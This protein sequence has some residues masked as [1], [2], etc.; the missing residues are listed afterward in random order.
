MSRS[1]HSLKIYN[2]KTHKTYTIAAY[3]QKEECNADN[4][5]LP[6][7]IANQSLFMPI[8]PY[9]GD[10]AAGGSTGVYT[11][12]NNK[13]YQ[14]VQNGEFYLKIQQTPNQTIT[15]HVG[16]QSWTDENEHWFPYGTQ[17]TATIVGHDGYNPGALNV[18]SGTLTDNNVTVTATGATFA[19]VSCTMKVSKHKTTY[20]CTEFTPSTIK[21]VQ[22]NRLT[23]AKH[24]H[25]LDVLV[26]N[27]AGRHAIMLVGGI[28]LDM[29]FPT[30]GHWKAPYRQDLVD[31]LNSH[32][33]QTV[34]I[35]ILVY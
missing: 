31:Y 33:E 26:T 3:T 29:T 12:K 28:S 16:G 1:P 19:Y 30:D 25:S 5:W 18:S 7:L 24:V 23:T 21:G 20:I 8:T 22:F 11:I 34:P 10:A 15:L 9:L 2:N 13:T 17:W 35:Q 4:N 27:G 14:I 6:L 32:I